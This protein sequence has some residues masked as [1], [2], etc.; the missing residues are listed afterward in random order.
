MENKYPQ[1]NVNVWAAGYV[2]RYVLKIRSAW[3]R[4][5]ARLRQRRAWRPSPVSGS[6]SAQPAGTVASLVLSGSSS[7]RAGS[8]GPAWRGAGRAASRST[9]RTG[10]ASSIPDSTLRSFL[11]GFYHLLDGRTDPD[12]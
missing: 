2:L 5:S 4:A 8:H 11:S 3:A 1:P 7:G 10:R 6:A 12:P 9:L